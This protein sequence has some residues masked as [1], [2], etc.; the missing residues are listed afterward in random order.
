MLFFWEEEVVRWRLLDQEEAEIRTAMEG[1]ELP[2]DV[3]EE[4]RVRLE[5]VRMKKGMKP[6]ERTAEG[7]GHDQ[8][9]GGPPQY[10]R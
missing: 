7:G 6:S 3:K 8:Q 4:L 2:E 1:G 9:G 10:E 5:S